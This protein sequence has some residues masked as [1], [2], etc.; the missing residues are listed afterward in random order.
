M[1]TVVSKNKNLIF[2]VDGKDVAPVAYMSY[3]PALASYQEFHGLGYELFS[4]CIYLGGMPVNELSGIHAFE[5]PIWKSRDVYDFSVVDN[6][7]RRAL[8]DVPKGYLMLRVNV[9]VPRWWREENPDELVEL[10]NGKKLMQSSFSK[11]WIKDIQVYFDRL[12]AHI[13]SSAYAKNVIAWQIAS[14]CLPI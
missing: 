11:K 8:G 5:P 6:V 7:V 1:K 9:N 3:L 4:A 2:N 10:S 14:S 12:K 13:E